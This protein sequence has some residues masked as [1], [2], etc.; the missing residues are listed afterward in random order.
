MQCLSKKTQRGS[1]F[2]DKFVVYVGEFV[3]K[4]FLSII[5]LNG[6]F[7]GPAYLCGPV[8]VQPTCLI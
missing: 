2:V 6:S 1:F 5:T 7:S 8:F 3:A 4:M